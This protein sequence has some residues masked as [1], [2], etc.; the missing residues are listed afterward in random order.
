M[1]SS[2]ENTSEVA[3]LSTTQDKRALL[4]VTSNDQ[5]ALL[6]VTTQDKGALLSTTSDNKGALLSVTSHGRVGGVLTR[7]SSDE[8]LLTQSV[9]SDTV[10]LGVK[11][12]ELHEMIISVEKEA[13]EDPW[14][15][16]FIAFMVLGAGFHL[17]F[18]SFV[19][20]V[21]Y[22]MMTYKR[23]N[24]AFIVASCYTYTV[25]GAVL[26]NVL[27][28]NK[29]ST[30]ARIHFGYLAFLVSLLAM[31]AL[32]GWT[33]VWGVGAT[34]GYLVTVTATILTGL[35]CGIQ[36][37][38]YYGYAGMLPPRYTRAIM[39]GEAFAGLVVC[40]NRIVTKL[41][42]ED[43]LT[44]TILFFSLSIV[45]ELVC[46]VLHRHVRHCSFIKYYAAGRTNERKEGKELELVST[47]LMTTLKEGYET[48]NPW[49]LDGR[50]FMVLG[51]GFHLPFNSFV[52][53]VDYFM[54]TYKR[55]NMAFIVASCYTYTVCGAVLLNVLLVNK[56]S[57]HARI[58]F[59]YLAFLVSLMAL[60]ALVGWTLV[61]GVGA[62]TG[63]LVTV[64]ATILTGLGCGIQEASYYGYAGMLPPRY[65]RAIMLGEAFAGLVVCLNRIVTKLTIE[66]ALTNT[67]L[68]FS[69]SIVGELVCVVLHRHVRHCSFIKYYAAGRTNE[70]K[71][72]KELE[73]V[74]T[75][76]MTT[77]KEGMKLRVR[78]AKKIWK[79]MLGILN[80]YFTT[81]LLYPGLTSVVHST[82]P[83]GWVAVVLITAFNL[84]DF[85]GTMATGCR[86][87]LSE[88][89]LLVAGVVR[90][91]LI[92]TLL[93]CVVGDPI[94]PG[95]VVP[96][97]VIMILGFTTGHMG[98]TP[99]CGAA[100]KLPP[101]ERE[102]GG[103][104]M[105]MMMLLGMSLGSTVAL[106]IN[107]A[108][109]AESGME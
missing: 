1:S 103:N 22:F 27:L 65:T 3:L 15:L 60:A 82:W 100:K 59:G 108:V 11:T 10:L 105:T 109:G 73:L 14:N 55:D 46:V 57:T 54:M 18:N 38:S 102:M 4:S 83:D 91:A 44:N 92:P 2:T 50:A 45:G 6:S 51:A 88:N 89:M 93:L 101:S 21:D 90:W 24:M 26:L 16:Y 49:N 81:F 52:A 56:V 37:A 12:G 106:V 43:A 94:I 70:K 61:W 58:H 97:I 80:V 67:I 7:D 68:F 84:A 79:L 98:S 31:A 39:L 41:T 66:D 30:H 77:L 28:V 62:T 40:L 13:P 86:Y 74:S 87:R 34:T 42:I 19:A 53:A 75:N 85:T 71:E 107:G 35:G 25:C 33:L 96:L 78:V 76:L 48:T 99:M 95:E 104:L 17:P 63:Y 69:L 64:T 9:R 8:S 47:N 5:G 23:D 72:G 29:V 32:V 36:E 20:A